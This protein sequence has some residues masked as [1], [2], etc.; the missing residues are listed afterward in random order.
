MRP[1]PPLLLLLLLLL[2]M[3]L[4]L[5]FSET[6]QNRSSDRP[7]QA[8]PYLVSAEAAGETAGQGAAEAAV[9]LFAFLGWVLG[10]CVGSGG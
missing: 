8:V 1:R 2:L 9:G 4:Q 10:L 6:T 3:R 5:V 7:E